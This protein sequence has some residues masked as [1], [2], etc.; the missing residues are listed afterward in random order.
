MPAKLS[1]ICLIHSVNERDSNNYIVREATAVVRQE[2]NTSMDLKIVSFISKD[3]SA[4][5]WVPLFQSGNV[6]RF[7]GKFMLE[8]AP[9]HG[10]LQVIF[11]FIYY[12]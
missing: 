2:D 12:F 1:L 10:I 6:L 8:D 4:P 9:P 5:R 3:T 7:T 11:W